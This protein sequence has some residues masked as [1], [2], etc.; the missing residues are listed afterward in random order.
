MVSDIVTGL[1]LFFVNTTAIQ[2]AL[3]FAIV[4]K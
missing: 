4:F 2:R 1:F 3:T